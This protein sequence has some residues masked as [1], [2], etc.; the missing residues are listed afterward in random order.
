MLKRP[1]L[2]D[3]FQK[4]IFKGCMREE[5]AGHVIS[6]YS[7]L[8]LVDIKITVLSINSQSGFKWS[9][10]YMLEVSSFHLVTVCFL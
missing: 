7:V 6:L 5:A 8:E 1:G 4:S 10:I 3:S 2:P 9:E